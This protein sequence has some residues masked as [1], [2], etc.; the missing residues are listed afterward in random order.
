MT[1]FEDNYTAQDYYQRDID[2][3]VDIDNCVIKHLKKLGYYNFNKESKI[4]DFIKYEFVKRIN[5]FDINNINTALT[6]IQNIK[7]SVKFIN[8]I[9]YLDYAE[10]RSEILSK[11]EYNNFYNL[12]NQMEL[13][14]LGF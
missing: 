2:C 11:C 5:E 14:I 3:N 1:S 13:D 4:N 10:I 12:C 6:I 8:Y 7:T 9:K